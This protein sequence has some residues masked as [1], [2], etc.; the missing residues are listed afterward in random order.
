M[1]FWK[2]TMNLF[3]RF[4]IFSVFDLEGTISL[5]HKMKPFP[6]GFYT[7]STHLQVI[8]ELITCKFSGILEDCKGVLKHGYLFEIL[9]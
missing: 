8:K 3:H 4:Y 2:N 5:P 1:N 6:T 7:D 9:V